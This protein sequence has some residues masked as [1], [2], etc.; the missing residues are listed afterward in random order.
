M[1]YRSVIEHKTR[2]SGTTYW[3]DFKLSDIG[4]H[5]IVFQR[6]RLTEE[7]AGHVDR[8]NAITVA[9]EATPCVIT[10]EVPS[11]PHLGAMV[12]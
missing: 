4:R 12:R 10:A 6:C 5:E 3:H 1:R 8:T 9:L 2:A 11:V 7:Y